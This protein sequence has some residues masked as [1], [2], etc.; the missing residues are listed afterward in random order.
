MKRSELRQLILDELLTEKFASPIIASIN[1][2]TNQMRNFWNSTANSYG[3]AWDKVKDEHVSTGAN[4]GRNF[5]NIFFVA[6]G[7]ENPYG[8][9]TYYYEDGKRQ[10]KPRTF[11]RDGLL[12]ITIGKKV[13]GWDGDYYWASRRNAE[14]KKKARVNED[15]KNNQ[16]GGIGV[17]EKVWN[18][19]R[20]KEVATEVFNI[21]INAVQNWN[22]EIK[23]LRAEQKSGAIALQ[24]N[25]E[26]LDDNKRR[27]KNA[28]RKIK[29]AGVEGKEFG[30]VMQHLEEAEKILGDE[31]QIKIKDTRN[32]VVYKGWDTPFGLAINYHSDMVK[33]FEDF[34]RYAQQMKAKAKE[35]GDDE[36]YYSDSWYKSYLTDIALKVKALKA[37]FDKRMEK[38]LSL[39]GTNIAES[40]LISDNPLDNM[41]LFNENKNCMIGEGNAFLAARAKAIE[42]E[43]EEFE[44]NGKIFPIIINEES[45]NEEYI[46]LMPEIAN[47]LGEIHK[48]WARWKSGPMTEKGDI[49][50]AQKELKG[51]I[52]RWFKQNIN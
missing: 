8:E 51:W 17:D 31:L 12:G 6:K 15:P 3:I 16:K 14:R 29:E 37:E 7:T 19:K 24:G 49:K 20:M 23:Q 33:M 42:E 43:A 47:A 1:N 50:P 52:E 38:A 48:A 10:A 27:Y 36:D 28:V 11:W 45:V 26:I 22:R 40:V 21:D 32:N 30:I 39:K 41:Q 2:R 9:F 13:I 4:G 46:E 5:I 18:F 44:F 25:K 34:Q 35:G